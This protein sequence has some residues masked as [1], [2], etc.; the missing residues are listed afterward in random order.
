MGTL[1]NRCRTII[2]T[3]KGIII[4]TTTHVVLNMLCYVLYRYVILLTAECCIMLYC[5]LRLE[6]VS[7]GRLNG[8]CFWL[9]CTAVTCRPGIYV[10]IPGQEEPPHTKPQ[11]RTSPMCCQVAKEQCCA[12]CHEADQVANPNANLTVTD[13]DVL[14]HHLGDHSCCDCCPYK[15]FL[16]LILL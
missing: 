15:A 3:P 13:L 4:L 12:H 10:K 1:N 2:R 8:R 9:A 5:I 14:H 7:F 6:P 16:L 11:D